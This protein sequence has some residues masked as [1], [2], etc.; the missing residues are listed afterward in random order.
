MDVVVVDIP[1]KFGMILSRSL[2]A[3]IKGT[4]QMYMSDATILVF[5]EMRRLYRETRLAYMVS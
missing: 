1:A 5:R 4:L 2:A 3:R